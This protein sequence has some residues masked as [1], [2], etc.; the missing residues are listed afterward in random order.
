MGRARFIEVSP[1]EGAEGLARLT[2]QPKERGITSAA[3]SVGGVGADTVSLAWKPRADDKDWWDMVAGRLRAGWIGD[4][5]VMPGVEDTEP[6]CEM[7]PSGQAGYVSRGLLSGAKLLIWPR[8]RLVAVE[9]RLAVLLASD[10]HAAGLRPPARLPEA[11]ELCASGLRRLQLVADDNEACTVRRLDLATDVVWEHGQAGSAL[12]AALALARPP[13][14]HKL[15]AWNGSRGAETV[16]LFRMAGARRELVGRIY[17]RGLWTGIGRGRVV[18]FERQLRWSGPDRRPVEEAAAADWTAD[19]LDWVET[20]TAP[21][22][23]D[24]ALDDEE[25]LLRV[26]E[27]GW[28]PVQTGLR[29]LGSLVLTSRRDAAEFWKGRGRN[30]PATGRKHR[31]ELAAL[32]L[33]SNA[34]LV[35]TPELPAVL[36]VTRADWRRAAAGPPIP[37][38]TNTGP[39]VLS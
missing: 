19:A 7:R 38:A 22:A 27:D 39:S 14:G 13:G 1:E 18:R 24:A 30:G 3:F 11:A 28:L 16:S 34:T 35:I 37:F 10:A 8:A 6:S 26:I 17:D 12:L 36:D 31:R 4:A 32:G 25:E 21:Q 29:L 15:N 20:L 2:G 23:G 5:D 33:P 9:G